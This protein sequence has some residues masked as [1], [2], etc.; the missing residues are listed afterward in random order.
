MAF[1]SENHTKQNNTPS[2]ENHF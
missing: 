2:W 1:Y